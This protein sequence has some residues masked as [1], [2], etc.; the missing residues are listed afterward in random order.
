MIYLCALC[1][2]F[3]LHPH[4][5]S[6]HTKEVFGWGQ[7]KDEVLHTSISLRGGWDGTA[8]RREYSSKFLSLSF[9]LTNSEVQGHPLK[10]S[11]SSV[12]VLPPSP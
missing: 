5:L 1:P 3:A 10:T 11:F 2:L 8:S 6:T 7:D 4:N 12:G 9:P